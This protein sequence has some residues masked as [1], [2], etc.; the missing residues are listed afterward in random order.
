RV[1]GVYGALADKD[2]AGVGR[3]MVDVVDA[4]Y[5]AGL[6][7][8]RGLSGQDLQARL[9]DSGIQ[10]TAFESV[11]EALVSALAVADPNDLVVVFGSFFTVAEAREILLAGKVAGS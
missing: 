6:K 5:L 8:P 3:A 10:A 2:V 1:H 9:S 7:V 11:R 4:W